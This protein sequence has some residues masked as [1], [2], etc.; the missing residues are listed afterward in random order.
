MLIILFRFSEVAIT[1]IGKTYLSAFDSRDYRRV[2]FVA[3]REEILRQ[4][5]RSFANVRPL[6]ERGFF[7]GSQK[8][9]N[10]DILF[11][12]VQSLGKK[13]SLEL[14]KSDYFDYIIVDEFH[15]A[16]AKNYQNIINYFK[17]QFLLGITATPDRLDSKDVLA[18]CDYNLVYEAPLKKA[19]NQGWLVPF[20]YYA[21]YDETVDYNQIDYR[22]G[23]Y[24]TAQLEEALSI[25]RRA[26]LILNHYKKY[27]SKQA[28]GF[29]TS[30][31]HAD[32]MANYFNDHGVLACA[33]YSGSE[34]TFNLARDK[35]IS[36]L[37]KG[38]IQ[39]I[40]S[41]DMFNEGLDIASLDMVMMLRPTESPTIFMQQLGRGLRLYK[42]K[43]YLN[44]LDFIG[45]YKKANFSPYLITGT[46][47]TDY[48][49]ASDVIKEPSLLPEDC[50]ID[51]DFRLVDL[52]EKIERSSL[53]IEQLLAEEYERIKAE[54]GHR[55]S[56]TELFTY[57]DETVYLNVK[58][59]AK[60]NPFKNYLAFLNKQNDLTEEEMAWLETPAANFINMIEKTSMSKTYKLPTL[61]AFIQKDQ[62]L[63]TIDDDL[64]Y[65]SFNEFYS[66]GSNAIDLLRDKSTQNFKQ[67]KKAE[68]VKLARKNP[69]HFLCQ[70]ESEFFTQDS[71]HVY[72]NTSL[73]PY[74]KDQ[75]FIEHIHDV[76]EFR[77]Q[78]FYR[79]R[80]E[81]LNASK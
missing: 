22:H 66:H 77:K 60:V 11:A 37:I 28:L 50:V 16:V 15:H 54:L 38:D 26:D 19:I 65:Q 18:I 49:R 62:L 34:G 17:P 5:D 39:V 68:F 67:W 78:E 4:A 29:C 27:R 61:L 23:K 43:H 3:H 58:T 51:F 63:L 36:Q 79:Q 56:R 9:V 32:F 73:A 55:P 2:L 46:S 45:N 41:V 71:E 8:D 53:K 47:K 21:I 13:E 59:K 80:L 44:V 14:F 48:K 70:S 1:G 42:D 33:V 81:K 72:L 64:L 31:R 10:K 6:S 24:Q 12:S 74:Q 76:I 69:I 25:H 75:L 30:K 35:A 52:F 57:I 40:F 20:R 7:M